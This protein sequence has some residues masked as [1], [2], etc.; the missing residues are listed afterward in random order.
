[1]TVV[2]AFFHRPTTNTLAVAIVCVLAAAAVSW[3]AEYSTRAP[4][5]EPGAD[6]RPSPPSGQLLESPAVVGLLTNEFTAPRAAVTATALDLAARGWVRLS[7]V[8][9]EPVVV[10]RG[11]PAQGDSLRPYEQQVLN[12]LA[13]RKIDVLLHAR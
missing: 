3:W 5:P 4:T 13:S 11:A 12:H 9:G 1:M 7:T 6:R 10:T 2:L 8:D